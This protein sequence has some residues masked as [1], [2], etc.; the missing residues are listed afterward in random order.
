MP[1]V[2]LMWHGGFK[3]ANRV[4]GSD[5]MPALF[6][7]SQRT[8]YRHFLYGATR[9]T[10]EL[11]AGKLQCK[12]PAVTIIG[13]HAPPFRPPGADED[14]TVIETIDTSAADIIW[15]GLSTPKQELLSTDVRN[16]TLCAIKNWTP[17]L[18]GCPEIPSGRLV[19]VMPAPARSVP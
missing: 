12:F 6:E 8:G 15:V 10:L 16:W 7:H 5:L 17:G 11:L 9:R 2:W 4:C 14:E 18:N 1:L 19:Q 13:T 3:F